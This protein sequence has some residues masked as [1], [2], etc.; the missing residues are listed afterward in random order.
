MQQ[1]WFL[2][3]YLLLAYEQS[4]SHS[5]LTWPFFSAHVERE[6]GEDRRILSVKSSC[7][8]TNLI[9]LGLHPMASFY[10]KYILKA[11]S[12]NTV[13]LSASVSTYTFWRGTLNP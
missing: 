6:R 4:L 5:I 13:T 12:P 9:R 7:K 8:A 10:R 2:V 11:L 3:S 1:D